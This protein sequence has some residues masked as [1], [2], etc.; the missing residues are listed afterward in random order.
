MNIYEI[1]G[2]SVVQFLKGAL[3]GSIIIFLLY[4]FFWIKNLKRNSHDTRD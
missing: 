2:W 3:I 4:L 1:I